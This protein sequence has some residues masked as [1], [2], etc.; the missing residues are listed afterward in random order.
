MADGVKVAEN[1][2]RARNR[3]AQKKRQVS[4]LKM[5]ALAVLY[6]Q[7]K[8]K[9]KSHKVAEKAFFSSRQISRKAHKHIHQREAERGDDNQNYALV[10]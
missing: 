4:F 2:E 3:P 8:G 9:N 7:S 1:T 6:H 5:K 10:L